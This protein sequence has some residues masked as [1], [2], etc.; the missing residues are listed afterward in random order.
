MKI[1]HDKNDFDSVLIELTG[2]EVKELGIKDIVW[3]R[4]GVD[5]YEEYCLDIKDSYSDSYFYYTSFTTFHKIF[6]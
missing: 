4:L 2:K 6:K 1:H 3:K 5:D